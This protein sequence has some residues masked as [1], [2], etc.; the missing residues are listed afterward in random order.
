MTVEE[1]C[2]IR[3]PV[4]DLQG[5]GEALSVWGELDGRDWLRLG[6]C[7]GDIVSG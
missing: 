2:E 5:E 4:T 7:E 1:S 3:E 6:A